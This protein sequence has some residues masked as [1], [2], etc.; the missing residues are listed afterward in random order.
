MSRPVSPQ[1][2]SRLTLFLIVTFGYAL[3]ALG[4]VFL[5]HQFGLPA[6]RSAAS[7]AALVSSFAIRTYLGCV[8]PK[9]P[10]DQISWRDWFVFALP[11]ILIVRLTGIV[12]EGTAEE[13]ENWYS[14]L[15]V[16]ILDMPTFIL[17]LLMIG[18]WMTGAL[19]AEQVD[20]LHPRSI[21]ARASDRSDLDGDASTGLERQNR[22]VAMM[23]LDRV[24]AGG[25]GIL[26][27]FSGIL[28][29]APP[30]VGVPAA[31]PAGIVL[32]ALLFYFVTILLLHSYASFVR[33]QTNWDLDHAPQS[34]GIASNWLRSTTLI[35]GVGLLLVAFLPRFPAPDLS[36]GVRPFVIIGQVVLG[37]L[38]LPFVAFAYLLKLFFSLFRGDGEGSETP[39]APRPTVPLTSG[40]ESDWLPFFQSAALWFVLA[41]M[42]YL[43]IRRLRNRRAPVPVLEPVLVALAA[44]F[45]LPGLLLAAIRGFLS[46]AGEAVVEA[47]GATRAGLS[48]LR[49]PLVSRGKAVEPEPLT[50]R[51]RVWRSYRA[52]LQAAAAAGHERLPDQTADEFRYALEPHLGETR[53]SLRAITGIFVRARYSNAAVGHDGVQRARDSGDRVVR[54]LQQ[55]DHAG[56]V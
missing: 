25:A 35:L 49:R 24:G 6:M 32:V 3:V 50:N 9:R 10:S 36:D 11:A 27:V 7:F 51:D 56:S 1:S 31:I 40:S 30:Y 13:Y 46:L 23:W 54:S 20:A 22:A 8:R 47:A 15:H 19:V 37:I 52:V 18:T 21:D 44:I 43:I 2:R 39:I 29:A 28:V 55:S 26:I 16:I 38:I 41:L 33:R 12:D 34:P 5:S 45:L 53:L 48:R 14:S 17:L 42:M 4:V